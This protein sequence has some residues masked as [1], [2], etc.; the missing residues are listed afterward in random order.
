MS[1]E[2]LIAENRWKK[3][4]FAA[5]LILAAAF[6][7]VVC[8]MTLAPVVSRQVFGFICFWLIFAVDM[9]VFRRA[10]CWTDWKSHRTIGVMIL[11]CIGVAIYGKLIYSDYFYG[12]EWWIVPVPVSGESPLLVFGRAFQTIMS[13]AVN[14]N[15]NFV[16]FFRFGAAVQVIVFAVLLF[17]FLYR[18]S[19]DFRL[20]LFV[21]TVVALSSAAVDCIGYFA[22]ESFMP[23]VLITSI[24]AAYYLEKQPGSEQ[25]WHSLLPGTVLFAAAVFVVCHY[26]QLGV[27]AIFL[28]VAIDLIFDRNTNRFL[29]CLKK[30]WGLAVGLLTGVILYYVTLSVWAHGSVN[31]RASTISIGDIPQKAR[32]F[33]DTVLPAVF[34]RLMAGFGGAWWFGKGSYW[35]L[36]AWQRHGVELVAAA[37]FLLVLAFGAACLIVKKR[38]LTL[39][40]LLVCVPASYGINLVLAENTYHT[41]YAF[42]LICVLALYFSLGIYALLHKTR[43]GSVVMACLCA[44]VV[45]QSSVYLDFG[46][47]QP[48]TRKT[49]YIVTTLS[50]Q[51]KTK[52]TN[53]IHFYGE[54]FYGEHPVYAESAVKVALRKLG[55]DSSNY[56]ITVSESEDCASIVLPATYALVYEAATE[57]QKHRLDETY[58]QDEMTQYY[59]ITP[60]AKEDPNTKALLQEVGLLPQNDD[61]L[62]VDLRWS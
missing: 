16:G 37:V 1:E 50:Y 34:D 62:I 12:D 13:E 61:W 20:S 45:I 32:W 56:R 48:N 5:E 9:E 2:R 8:R 7:A 55:I 18:K 59:C 24:A 26:Y 54:Q 4:G 23:S 17:D 38:F 47:I 39:L 43:F 60:E 28:F 21:S 27:T 10:V 15:L 3:W 22:I 51:M 42:S 30:Y 19:K 41:Y 52:Q 11:T 36:I 40:F 58:V 25:K 31:S 53:K 44:L 29:Y 6:S 46:W 49:D 14:T 35:Y 57:D 33:F